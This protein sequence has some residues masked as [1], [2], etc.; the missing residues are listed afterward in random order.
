VSVYKP[1]NSK[2]YYY[3]FELNGERY[4]YSTRTRNRRVAE[5]IEV[6][7]KNEI[8]LGKAGLVKKE[9]APTLQE[10][11]E[12]FMEEI[13]KHTE[14]HPNTYDFYGGYYNRLL[15]FP[16]IA[17]LRLDQIDENLIAQFQ[18]YEIKTQKVMPATVNRGIATLRKAMRLAL[19]WKLIDSVPKFKMLPEER[20]RKFIFTPERK[21]LWLQNA[22][23][24]LNV[25]SEF[26]WESGLCSGEMCDLLKTSVH[27]EDECDEDCQWGYVS[28]LQGKRKVRERSV[29]ITD[30]MREILIEMMEESQGAYVFYG[31]RDPERKKKLA[32]NTISHQATR[33]RRRLDW[34]WDC[35]LHAT[36]HTALTE[37]GMAGANQFDIKS[38]AGHNRI[39]TS[40]KYIHPT[41]ES[42]KRAVAR[43]KAYAD[44]QM[45]RAT[46]KKPIPGV[47]P[48]V[49]DDGFHER[50]EVAGSKGDKS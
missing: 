5:Q 16:K 19:E 37:L 42:M 24:P 27:L 22:P 8:L 43:K 23:F 6:A 13:E 50:G 46:K 40:E 17:D 34:P 2:Y 48:G 39:T 21:N 32:P 36:R 33:L 38:F 30:R 4:N 15:G 28:V 11:R 14:R 45:Q 25:I 12:R 44:Q 20:E 29:P 26:G 35:V 10:F 7:R 31:P 3:D 9:P 47:F 41:N 49:Q 1:S 18:T